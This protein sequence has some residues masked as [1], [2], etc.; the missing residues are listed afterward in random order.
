MSLPLTNPYCF[1]MLFWHHSLR[2]LTICPYR[3]LM[4][5]LRAIM[6]RYYYN[7]GMLGN[8]LFRVINLP[9][10]FSSAKLESQYFFSVNKE[11]IF[12][13]LRQFWHSYF[14]C[15]PQHC[16]CRPIAKRSGS[17]PSLPLALLVFTFLDISR[18]SSILRFSSGKVVF[19]KS[20]YMLLCIWEKCYI[21]FFS[22]V[23]PVM[24][25]PFNLILFTKPPSLFSNSLYLVMV[26]IFLNALAAL[27]ENLYS[28]SCLRHFS[29]S[30][31]WFC[32]LIGFI[33][34]SIN[35][36]FN[37][38][39]LMCSVLS[40]NNY[41]FLLNIISFKSLMSIFSAARSS[42]LMLLYSWLFGYFTLEGIFS[43]VYI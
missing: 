2:S 24:I 18:M 4:M 30:F 17:K 22:I 26:F 35:S 12:S 16:L 9:S 19:S 32:V 11:I 41:Y 1:G 21:I 28:W 13:F 31:C 15:F 25:Y 42:F 5:G 8:T 23:Y 39:C 3:N 14:V 20:S 43:I 36:L 27:C 34:F 7:F 38:F 10:I 29:N 37:L 40:I 33:A 6:G